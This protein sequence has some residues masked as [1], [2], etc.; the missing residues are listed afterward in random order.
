MILIDLKNFNENRVF[1][2]SPRCFV[3]HLLLVAFNGHLMI[4]VLLILTQNS[5]S[6]KE[7]G[8]HEFILNCL[9]CLNFMKKKNGLAFFRAIKM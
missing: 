4:T 8:F 9:F 2:N 3:V 6:R 7:R 1:E 5:S